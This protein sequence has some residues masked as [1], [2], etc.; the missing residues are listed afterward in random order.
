MQTSSI[1]QA[2]ESWESFGVLAL[3]LGLE[4]PPVGLQEP[5]LIT[6]WR[7]P[8]ASVWEECGSSVGT[9]I[10]ISKLLSTTGYN[11]G[12]RDLSFS[13]RKISVSSEEITWCTGEG[14]ERP[15]LFKW[16]FKA[17]PGSFTLCIPK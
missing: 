15:G 10:K 3:H 1:S 17:C 12:L 6:R 4:L 11:E 14:R 8:L 7:T 2:F 5:H 16:S 13:L 9:A